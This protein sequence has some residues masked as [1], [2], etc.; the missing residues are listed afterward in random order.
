MYYEFNKML[1]RFQTYLIGK[2]VQVLMSN[3]FQ[4]KLHIQIISLLIL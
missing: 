2:I 4:N 1:V 3:I